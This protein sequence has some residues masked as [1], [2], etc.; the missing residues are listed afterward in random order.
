[1]SIKKYR[2]SRE[3]F[4]QKFV[5]PVQVLQKIISSAGFTVM[6]IFLR[7]STA[8][9]PQM[10]VA[11]KGN[12]LGRKEPCHGFVTPHIFAH[13]VAELQ[14]GVHGYIRDGIHISRDRMGGI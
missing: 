5:H 4:V 7:R 13:A 11:G 3:L 9:V 10:I 14:Y 1:M 2:Q 8:A 12:A 6:A